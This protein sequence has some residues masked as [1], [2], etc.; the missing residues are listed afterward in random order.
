VNSAILLNILENSGVNFFTGVPD[1]L[2]KALCDEILRRYGGDSRR[3]L[4]AHN[5]GGAA[6]YA[7]GYHLAT[8]K[9]PC[10]YLQNSGIGNIVNPV[11]SLTSP[12][13]YGV[14]VLYV[15][16]W[17]GQ[18]GAPD[19]PQHKFQGIIT[20]DL[21]K[22]LDIT[23]FN[24]RAATT[25]GELTDATRG[26]AAP[27]ARGGSAAILVEAG[28]LTGEKY[29]HGSNW[30]L[31]RET[32]I[33]RVVQ[34]AGG[35]IIVSSTGKISREL[36]EIRERGGG[37]HDC[38]FLTVGSMGHDAMIAIGIAV[39]K[40]ERQ[41]WCLQGDGAFL[42][43]MG[44]AALAGSVSARNFRHVVLNNAAHESVGG[45]PTCAG[46]VD[47]AGIAAACGYRRIFHAETAE[48]LDA[49]LKEMTATDG[50][51][52]LEVKC[53]LGSRNDLGRPATSPRDNKLALMRTLSL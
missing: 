47:M 34:E 32:A 30:T 31:T 27:F 36:Y 6:A 52:F 44:A 38:D 26:F 14:P 2:L 13:V 48:E 17:R 19:E 20:D 53:S 35:A 12:L 3:H 11:A 42:M 46:S 9:T 22:I 37:S 16:G 45:M 23:V 24:L 18:P 1:S 5:E 25:E 43:H 8:G 10:V 41:V 4:V 29:G 40:P 50:A 33:E 49:A 39:Q 21:L 28:A 51:A 7:A 15:V